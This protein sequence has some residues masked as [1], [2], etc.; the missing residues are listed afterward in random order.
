MYVGANWNWA[1]ILFLKKP[2]AWELISEVIKGR[3][4]Y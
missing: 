3:K 1:T 2:I 4:G